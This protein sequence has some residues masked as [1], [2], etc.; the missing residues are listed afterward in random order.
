MSKRYK[1]TAPDGSIYE[2]DSPGELGGYKRQK[3]YGRLDYSS[4]IRALP[5]GYAQH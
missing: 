5:K 2:S 4:A 3:I 1:P